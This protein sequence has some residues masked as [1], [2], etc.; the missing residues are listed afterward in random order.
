M[1]DILGKKG[2]VSGTVSVNSIAN[3]LV[4]SL[5]SLFVLDP[6]GLEKFNPIPWSVPLWDTIKQLNKVTKLASNF[7]GE[8]WSDIL[9]KAVGENRLVYDSLRST[10]LSTSFPDND[11]GRQMELI[12]KMIKTKDSRGQFVMTCFYHNDS[13]ILSSL[14]KDNELS[15]TIFG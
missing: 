10:S 9:F 5:T 11:L 14:F 15:D 1:A 7:F 4:S 6:S 8:T 3:A 13:L 2:F 12:A